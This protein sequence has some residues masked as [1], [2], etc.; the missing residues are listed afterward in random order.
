MNR[1]AAIV[2]LVPPPGASVQGGGCAACVKETPSDRALVERVLG[3]DRTVFEHI[4]TRHEAAL[5]RQ[6]WWILRNR[7]DAE[8]ATQ[9]AFVRAWRA[10]PRFDPDRDLRPWLLTIVANV[11]RTMRARRGPVI[12]ADN[13]EEILAGMPDPRALSPAAAAGGREIVAAVS[14]AVSALPP[15]AAAVFEMRYAHEM[16]V[17]EIARRVGKKPGTV[18]VSLHRLRER[19]R[20]TLFPGKKGEQR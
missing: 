8:D 14:E 7:E 20:E 1:D 15:E 19:L 12:V 17:E 6:A 9:E 16:S 10:L 5:Y 4:V 13:A 3:G 18:A 2:G 11:A